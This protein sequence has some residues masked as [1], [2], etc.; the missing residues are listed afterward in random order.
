MQGAG[1]VVGA[2]VGF[3]VGFGV[4]GVVGRTVGATVGGAVGGRLGA[5]VGF[6]VGP[7]VGAAVGAAVG[8]EVGP[9]VGL[10][11]EPGDGRL[12]GIVVG[13]G[14]LPGFALDRGPLDVPRPT[15]DGLVPSRLAAPFARVGL[16]GLAV[17]SNDAVSTSTDTR[18][19]A[20]GNGVLGRRPPT[21]AGWPPGAPAVDGQLVPTWCRSTPDEKHPVGN[22]API[23]RAG[24]RR[25]WT[26]LRPM[27]VRLQALSIGFLALAVVVV[28]VLLA[29]PSLVSA[30]GSSQAATGSGTP[31][32]S[33]GAGTPAEPTIPPT[34][35]PRPSEGG[36][37]LYGYL[38]YWQMSSSIAT[39]LQGAPLST[40]ALFSV[41][42]KKSGAIDPKPL[43][44]RRITGA[45][46]QQLITEAHGRGER[47][48]I[49]FS[50]FGATR[51]GQLF[52]RIP[53]TTAPPASPSPLPSAGPFASLGV[54]IPTAVPTPVPSPTV[55]PIAPWHRT[56]SDLV[57]LTNQ[58]GVDGVNVD[59][60][61]LDPRDLAAYGQFLGALRPALL[62]AN[63]RATLTVATEAGS[64]GVAK[65]ATAS[66]TGVDRIFLMGYDYHWSGSAPGASAPVDRL[67]GTA[68]LRWSIDQYVGAGVPRDRIIL[69]LPLYGMT[70]RVTAPL[71]TAPV[72]GNGIA[73]IPSQHQ[74]LLLDPAFLPLRDRYEQVE[75]FDVS[76]GPD[77]LL[78]FYD[79]PD[80][81]RPKL[82]LA[83]DNGL[84]G[85]GFWAMGYD[86]GLPGYQALMQAFRAG[87]VS[88]NEAPPRPSPAPDDLVAAPSP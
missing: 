29:S 23:V 49:V 9:A 65:A 88:R 57:A 21:V 16:F 18:T 24:R 5:S 61:Q 33:G 25:P 82:A 22:R 2:G 54:P 48:D 7:V 52:G 86:R 63:P 75:S 35:T 32:G 66:A 28:A 80:T 31:N 73:W 72:I 69:G 6:V 3:D 71:R 46:G 47:V 26:T 13:T 42:A 40:L 39:Y 44:Y 67:D 64:Q 53:I 70:W 68:T 76:D 56:I 87:T 4:G 43:G 77:W 85:A 59:I 79:S 30:P 11:V 50:S 37:E 74:D 84:A 55:P 81:L 78:T 36:T 14:A 10:D 1:I 83:R 17:G 41:T 58:L 20:S 12:V 62:A 60:E 51:N 34:P 27:R 45:I 19:A 15:L 8:F 38:P